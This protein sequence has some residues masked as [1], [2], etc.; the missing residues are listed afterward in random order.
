MA[1]C[2]PCFH[3]SHTRHTK[4]LHTPAPPPQVEAKALGLEVLD[5]VT[6]QVQFVKV[7]NDEL[8][9]LMGTAG[10]KDLEPPPGGEGSGQ[11]QVVLLAGL[12]GVGKT[13]AAGKL[14]MFL[15]KR[16]KKVRRGGGRHKLLAMQQQQQQMG[17]AGGSWGQQAAAGDAPGKC[18]CRHSAV[19]LQTQK[20]RLPVIFSS[21]VL[22]V[23][24][25]VYRPAAIDQ[26]VKLGTKIDV[27]VYE[28]G[29]A[30]DPVEI[31]ARGVEKAKAE[32][33]DAVIVDTAG[34]LQVR[35]LLVVV[36]EC[37]CILGAIGPN[38]N[39]GFK[40]I[41]DPPIFPLRYTRASWGVCPTK[42]STH[43]THNTQHTNAQSHAPG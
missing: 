24:T 38:F 10:S 25:D 42:T 9:D 19:L 23:A 13:T 29:T 18:S 35:H 39:P 32:G 7:V 17:K 43:T 31:A 36:G 41:V 28:E 30:A 2:S 37:C 33:Y 14:A 22:L 11:P 12:Q 26:L 4:Y 34:R 6:P 8:I 16:R 15:T 27:P 1:A 40:L 20:A 3:C 21:Q 5:G